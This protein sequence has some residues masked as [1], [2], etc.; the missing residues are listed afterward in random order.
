M[1]KLRRPTKPPLASWKL[2]ESSVHSGSA[3][4]TTRTR[5]RNAIRIAAACRSSRSRRRLTRTCGGAV[6]IATSAIGASAPRAGGEDAQSRRRQR[7]QEP[8]TLGDIEVAHEVRREIRDEGAGGRDLGREP[9]PAEGAEKLQASD[10]DADGVGVLGLHPAHPDLLGSQAELDGGSRTK[11]AVVLAD[12]LERARPQGLRS[13]D[14]RIEE[15]HGA[16]EIG[17]EGGRRRAIDL[18][19]RA[20]LL[21]HAL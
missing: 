19:R 13:G 14:G 3:M 2:F 11:P 5:A 17:D 8:L 9:R 20:D 21:D 7:D 1:P 16:D 4:M 15:A 6:P 18:G 10:L 12:E